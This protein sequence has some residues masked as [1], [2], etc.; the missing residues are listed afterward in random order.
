[1]KNIAITLGIVITVLVVAFFGLNAYI[2][3]EKQGDPANREQP[4]DSSSIMSFSDCEAAGYPIMESYP[5]QCKVPDGRTYAEEIPEK[6]T[7]MNASADKIVVETPTPG[8]VTGKSFTVKGKARGY[9]YF[10]ASFPI[11]LLDKDGKV[12]ASMPVQAQGDW[13]TE[14]FVPFSVQ[15]TAPQSYIGPATLVLHKDNPS[16]L[17]ENDASLS[18]PIT[19]EY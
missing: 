5:R 10:E 4:T 18:I 19:V 1:M 15:I 12:L 9:W 3:N 14:N 17:P 8:A 16:G 7:Y 2:C 11:E 13:M 6:A